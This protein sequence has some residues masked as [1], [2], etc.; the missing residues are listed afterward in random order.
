M[1]KEYFGGL[2][3]IGA[4]AQEVAAA[5][6]SADLL[7]SKIA[8]LGA[9]NPAVVGVSG[10]VLKDT[11]R[12]F[13]IISEDNRTRI[14]PKEGLSFVVE[15]MGCRIALIGQLL[16]RSPAMKPKTLAF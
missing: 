4:L 12:T 11:A 16:L 2:C 1:W 13:V 10:I 14:L 9:R 3:S 7:G 8:V 6:E 5:V 15:A